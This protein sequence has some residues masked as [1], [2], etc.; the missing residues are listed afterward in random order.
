MILSLF[1]GHTTATGEQPIL[2]NLERGTEIFLPEAGP[3]GAMLQVPNID[4][5]PKALAVGF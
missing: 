4:V 2:K 1:L 5:Y 3:K